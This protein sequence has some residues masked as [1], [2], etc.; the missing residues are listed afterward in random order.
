MPRP[1]EVSTPTTASVAEVRAAFG[2]ERYWRARLR[3]YGGDSITLDR[4]D[5]DDEGTVMVQ[6]TQDM[7][8]DAMPGFIAKAIPGD[9]RVIRQETWRVADAEL[10]ADVAMRTTGAPISGVATA[11]VSPTTDGSVLRFAGT[12]QVKVPLIGGQ[13][14]KYISSQIVEEIPGVQRFTTRWIAE[15]A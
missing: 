7:R 14:E 4:L 12:V 13:I 9:L 2:S 11:V 6:T 10:H 8:N 3:E 15:N 5:V 1:F